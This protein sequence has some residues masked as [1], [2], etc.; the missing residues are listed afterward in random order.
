MLEGGSGQSVPYTT[1]VMVNIK[2]EMKRAN[3]PLNI[4]ICVHA[5]SLQLCPMCCDPMYYSPPGP[6]VPGILQARTLEWVAISSFRGSSWPRDQTH[7]SCVSYI[8][9][10][11]LYHLVSPGKPR[12]IY[13]ERERTKMQLQFLSHIILRTCSNIRKYWKTSTEHPFQDHNC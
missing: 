5:K 11:V 7:I 6:S 10:Q 2:E 1:T 9:R 8:G 3:T 12:Y 4:Y 13:R